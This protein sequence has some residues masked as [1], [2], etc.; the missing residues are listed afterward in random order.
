MFDFVVLL[1]YNIHGK[2]RR[3]FFEINEPI[4]MNQTRGDT[5]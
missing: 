4:V 3:G 1:L 5:L 2:Q